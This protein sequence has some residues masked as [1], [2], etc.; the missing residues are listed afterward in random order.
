MDAFLLIRL[1]GSHLLADFLLQGDTRVRERQEKGWRSK[2]LYTHAVLAGGLA[3]LFSAEWSSWW[4]PGI[5]AVTHAF[6]DGLK[7]ESEDTAQ[8][9]ILDQAAHIT[10]IT[11]CWAFLTDRSDLWPLVIEGVRNPGYWVVVFSYV[12]IVW[13][14]GIL[15][16][17][18]TGRWRKPTGE[19]SP[20]SQGLDRAGL[21]IG[22]LERFLILTFVLL[23]HFEAIGFLIAAKSIF[24]FSE[25]RREAEYIIIGSLLSFSIA[26]VLGVFVRQLLST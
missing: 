9:F 5:I 25:L 1:L 18:V 10:V 7:V 8:T 16:G 13:P 12:I 11:A 20:P 22:R 19:D 3:Y 26:I 4:L 15:I 17:K 6:I 2:W 21:L 23:N 14:A 24:R